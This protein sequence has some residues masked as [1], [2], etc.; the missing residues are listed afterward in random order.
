[1]EILD[2]LLKILDP[3]L[4]QSTDPSLVRSQEWK[5]QSHRAL[6]AMAVIAT[7]TNKCTVE[8]GVSASLVDT[9]V[10]RLVTDFHHIIYWM[11]YLLHFGFTLLQDWSGGVHYPAAYFS[12]SRSLLSVLSYDPR[13][14]DCLYS[15]PSAMDLVFQFWMKRGDNGEPYAEFTILLQPIHCWIIRLLLHCVDTK[16][17][18]TAMVDHIYNKSLNKWAHF[19]TLATIRCQMVYWRITDKEDD[20]YRKWAP[21]GA[22][23]CYFR[24]LSEIVSRLIRDER[25]WTAFLKCSFVVDMARTALVLS[26]KANNPKEH[27]MIA[28]QFFPSFI[29]HSSGMLYC[30]EHMI[31]LGYFNYLTSQIGSSKPDLEKAEPDEG[32][33]SLSQ[34]LLHYFDISAMW[35]RILKRMEVHWKET[36]QDMWDLLENLPSVGSTLRHFRSV[37]QQRVDVDNSL[38]ELVILCDNPYC[39]SKLVLLRNAPKSKKC[40]GC[41][42]FAYCSEACQEEDWR[43]F[44]QAECKYARLDHRSR[45]LHNEVYTHRMRAFHLAL[46][47]KRFN[48][49]I[50]RHI[51][52]THPDERPKDEME[53]ATFSPNADL[54]TSETRLYHFDASQ[55]YSRILCVPT[56]TYQWATLPVLDQP[57]MQHRFRE[58]YLKDTGEPIPGLNTEGVVPLDGS[59]VDGDIVHFVEGIFVMGNKEILIMAKLRVHTDALFNRSKFRVASSMVRIGRRSPK[60]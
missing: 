25:V 5:E 14:M 36:P 10:D 27:L 23:V 44:H 32:I 54:T 26:Q 47:E 58:A 15:S 60:D 7:I 2:L 57:Y 38:R 4:I 55:P 11:G 29:S 1:M 31:C 46:I 33:I 48:M 22:C 42:S 18:L 13:M 12:H 9:L 49:F 34:V 37:I 28:A 52:R 56:G 30:L 20:P 3:G 43:N 41:R 19:I 45:K 50:A 40:S 8:N 24:E 21:P 6:L 35:P 51:D 17:G 39:R 16:E 59:G 53:T